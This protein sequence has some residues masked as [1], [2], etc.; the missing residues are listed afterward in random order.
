MHLHFATELP[1]SRTGW[2]LPLT[3]VLASL[4]PEQHNA[5]LGVLRTAVDLKCAVLF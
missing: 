2:P 5:V 3:R 4:G 1:Q